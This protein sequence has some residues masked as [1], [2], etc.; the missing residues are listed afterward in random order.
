M[1]DRFVLSLVLIL[2]CVPVRAQD[3]PPFEINLERVEFIQTRDFSESKTYLIPT[4]YLRVAARNAT[5]V[6]NE[7]ARANSMVYVDG[8]EKAILQGLAKKVYDDLIAK[9][10][11]AGFTVLDYNDV[12]AELAGMERMQPNPKFGFPTKLF[13]IGSPIDYAI[14][15]PS[16]EQAID[17]GSAWP[18]SPYKDIIK[19]RNAVVVVPEIYFNL[20]EVYGKKDSGW[21]GKSASIEIAPTMKLYSGLVWGMGPKQS[22]FRIQIA[23]HGKR[24]AAEV[25]GSVKKVAEDKNDW[26][27]WS[28]TNA[29]FSFAIEP[30]AFSNGILRVG[31]AINDLTVKTIKKAHN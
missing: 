26:G 18:I 8:L 4:V 29:D 14:V 22:G 21:F 10:R 5:S 16:D 11:A 12:K 24:L 15:T 23:E 28:V 9:V 7:G 17:W 6:K 25:A 31:Y 3:I 13:T 2:F 20:P 30:V 19:T 1:F 27:N